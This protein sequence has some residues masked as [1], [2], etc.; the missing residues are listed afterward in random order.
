LELAAGSLCRT[1][2]V[3]P[4]IAWLGLVVM[5]AGSAVILAA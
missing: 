3:G 1:A 5:T 2:L 4:A